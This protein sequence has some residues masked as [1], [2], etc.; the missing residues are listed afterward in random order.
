MHRIWAASVLL[1]A[2][3]VKAEA[4]EV[5]AK[6]GVA[7][8]KI[9]AELPG[10]RPQTPRHE[11]LPGAHVRA[12]S[13]SKGTVTDGFGFFKLEDIPMGDTLEA[14]MV[15]FQAV[16]WVF[17]GE[18]FTEI[19]LI[20]GI[21][22]GAAEVK[23][24]GPTASYSLLDPRHVQQ[25]NRGELVK[26]AC[27]NL[28]E[29]FE[30]NASVDAAFTDAITG[31]RQIRMLGLDGKYTSMQVDNL[32]GPRGLAVVEGLMLIPGDW[33]NGIAI[34]KGAGSVVG[35]YES[36]TGEIHVGLMNPMNA[37]KL[38]VNLYQN[39]SGRTEFN[40]V[41][42]H[43]ISRR[44]KMTLLTH[45]LQNQAV[46][47]RNEDGF[48]DVP[49]QRHGIVRNEW[50]FMGDRGMEGEYSLSAIRTGLAAG[51][52]G[53]FRGTEGIRDWGTLLEQPDTSGLRW[54]AASQTSRLEATAKTG[55]VFADKPGRSIGTQFSGVRFETEQ[56][57]GG[58][59]YRG[60]EE[61]FRANL[62]FADM[63][64]NS[65]H[66]ITT[67]IS[68][69]WNRFDE[70]AQ[71]NEEAGSPVAEQ[72]KDVLK[73]VESVP[74]IFA[75]YTYNDDI[76][77]NV[78]AGLRADYHNLYGLRWTPRIHA[79]WS[80]TEHVALKASAGRGWRVPNPLMEQR[81]AWASNRV[82]WAI[83][84]GSSAPGSVERM[85]LPVAGFQPEVA[86]NAGL[87]LTTKFRLGHRESG[88]AL[89][90][91]YTRFQNR[92]VVDLDG[93]PGEVW[94]YNLEGRSE[95]FSAQAEWDWSFHRRWDLRVALRYVE[96]TTDRLGTADRRDPFVPVLRAF[97][98]WSYASKVTSA[99]KQWRADATV[100]WMGP[101]RIPDTGSLPEA[102]QRPGDVPGF[103][104]VNTQVTRQFSERF[105]VY[106]G[107]ENL[108]NVRQD[109]P[110]LGQGV[111]DTA[112][113]DR[114]FDA[115]LVYGPIFGRMM[116]GGL[117][118]RIEGPSE[119]H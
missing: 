31:T 118:W 80:V 25:L 66:R 69:L 90:A 109:R 50:K 111:E 43:D 115:S 57:F 65:A 44:W 13:S 61:M 83:A 89:D 101:Q 11:A 28:S 78:I 77:W 5:P 102:F 68:W 117:R 73:R 20:S 97:S 72:R 112:L 14:S 35:G 119:G 6:T 45:G 12:I 34:S 40:H 49:L 53:T 87:S 47:D 38:H 4:Q 106:L 30:T 23:S 8:G 114:H 1:L 88:L 3:L 59:R 99:G 56:N 42:R 48:L 51:T 96:A 93:D 32:P 79:R 17:T 85:A 22:L 74:G 84:P 110:I 18:D 41:S 103:L 55:F 46:N 67:G 71:W 100:Q 27:C 82:W 33:V 98:Q 108:T 36:I 21:A 107:V 92:L 54:S 113:F 105:D 76:R 15:G 91:F 70:A 62:L 9:Y 64:G 24:D 16:R 104:Q 81:G 7:K 86:D 39:E 60:L 95:A 63:L 94:L 29:A 26:A 52:V 116:Y 37:P 2:I 10:E 75:E 19:P 58:A